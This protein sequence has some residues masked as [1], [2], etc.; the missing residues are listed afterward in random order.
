MLRPACSRLAVIVVAITAV[1][2]GVTFLLFHL[3]S[4]FDGARL[5]PGQP[6]WSSG[7]V[8]VTPIEQQSSGLAPGD[9]VVTVEG[10]AWRPG[11]RRCFSPGLLDR[12][13]I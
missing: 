7:G 3:F 9:E 6:Y 11:R 12:S 4:P 2:L 10:K 5:A 8:I 1:L 13:G